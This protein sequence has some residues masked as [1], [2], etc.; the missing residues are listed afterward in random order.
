MKYL[1]D[2]NIVS[3]FSDP[4]SPFYS[5]TIKRFSA[6]AEEDTVF[7]SVLTFYE[8]EYG[9]VYAPEEKKKRM[10]EV[11]SML[12]QFLLVLPV[13]A[14]GADSFGRIKARY[15][16]MAGAAQKTVDRHDV[17][18]ILASSAIAEEAVLVSNDRIF[19]TVQAIEPALKLENWAGHR[20][21]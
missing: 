5:A 6:L 16:K 8:T 14:A 19:L 1:L 18:F 3:Y 15:R 9:I 11:K 7:I 13:S 10:T 4:K 20:G 12:Q 2:T 17:D 21:N